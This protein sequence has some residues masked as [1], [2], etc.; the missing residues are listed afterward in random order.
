MNIKLKSLRAKYKAKNP[1]W[2][3]G[4]AFVYM[5]EVWVVTRLNSDGTIDAA[6]PDMDQFGKETLNGGHKVF[7]R[8]QIRDFRRIDKYWFPKPGL[9]KEE[10]SMETF[11]KGR[12]PKEIQAEIRELKR[13]AKERGITITSMMNRQASPEAARINERLFALKVELERAKEDTVEPSTVREFVATQGVEPQNLSS[14]YVLQALTERYNKK[15]KT[16]LT[17][18]EFKELLG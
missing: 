5:Y 16:K 6:K 15:F 3:K 7:E 18:Q 12:T 9:A 17:V 11:A 2:K 13:E 1:D 4:D 8:Y 14:S 10:K